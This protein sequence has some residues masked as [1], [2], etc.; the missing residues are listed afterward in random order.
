ME[1]HPASIFYDLIGMGWRI[2]CA[3]GEQ[4]TPCQYLEEAGAEMDDHMETANKEMVS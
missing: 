3:C 4:T 2:E 1:H